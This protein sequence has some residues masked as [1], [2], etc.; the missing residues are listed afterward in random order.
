MAAFVEQNAGE[1]Q[2][3]KQGN[4]EVAAA[5][6]EEEDGLDFAVQAALEKEEGPK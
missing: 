4:R 3:G 5:G 1:K 6:E 2:D